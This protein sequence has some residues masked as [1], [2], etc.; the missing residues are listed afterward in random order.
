MRQT[1]ATSALI[2]KT[3]GKSGAYRK[4]DTGLYV[5]HQGSAYVTI[6][7]LDSGKEG[8][9]K[10]IVRIYAQVVSGVKPEPSLFRQLLILNSRMRFGA[11]AYIPEGEVILFSHSILGGENMDPRELVATVGDVA[12]IAD[13]YDDRIVARYGGQRMQDVVEDSAMERL[14]A[15]ASDELD[16]PEPDTD[17]EHG[18]NGK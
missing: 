8:H 5:V 9:E 1:Q 16:F 13:G 18:G 15:D 14:M 3:L 2:E 17:S 4:V 11:F 12:L 7:V 10:P 6:S